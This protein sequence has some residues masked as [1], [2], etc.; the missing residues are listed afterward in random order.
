MDL[1]GFFVYIIYCYASR[2][3]VD[4]AESGPNGKQL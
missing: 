4:T 3:N 1:N 2:L